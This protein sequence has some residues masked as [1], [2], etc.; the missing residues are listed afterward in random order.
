MS[1]VALE[2]T[3]QL[4]EQILQRFD[5]NLSVLSQMIRYNRNVSPIW[6]HG[7]EIIAPAAGTA[8]VSRT[9]S[10]GKSGY[11]YGF[12]IMAGEANDFRIQW[13][14]G[15][16]TYT[17]RIPFPGKGAV[18]YADFIPLNEGLPAAAGSTISIVNVNAGSTGVVY[19]ARL[20]Y[21]EV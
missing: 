10:T 15:G 5:T 11:I 4:L 6:V 18:H 3:E 17:I 7:G 13:V 19:Q 14:S 2:I 16:T 1:F 8:L 20:L 21:A 9:V 12:Y